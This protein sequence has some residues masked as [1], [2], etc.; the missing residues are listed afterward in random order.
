MVPKSCSSYQHL[1]SLQNP[2]LTEEP[3][4]WV[5][6]DI[7]TPP[8]DALLPRASSQC[9]ASNVPPRKGGKYEGLWVCGA[10]EHRGLSLCI[11]GTEVYSKS[12]PSISLCCCPSHERESRRTSSPASLGAAPADL[13][14]QEGK[15]KI[16]KEGWLQG[17][18]ETTSLHVP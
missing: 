2:S 6:P 15:K 3:I 5:R 14:G 1:W 12:R 16:L 10:L 11:P 13:V 9:W 17:G 7:P 8:Y 18:Y 4:E